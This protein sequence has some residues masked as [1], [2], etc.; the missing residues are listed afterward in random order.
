MQLRYAFRLSPGPHQRLALGRAFGCARVVFNDE[1]RARKDALSPELDHPGQADSGAVLA[2]GGVL[3][4]APRWSIT[5]T[6]RLNLPK[7]G[8]VR[9][10]WS[11]T[12]PVAPSSVTVLKDSAA[13]TSRAL[14][15]TPT[16]PPTPRGCP[17][18][19]RPSEST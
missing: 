4:G 14:S 15:S 5:P 19:T 3:G 8:E 9:V 18:P 7:I 2:G 11:R 1:V 6:G 10:K 12:L 13:G 16:R 17:P